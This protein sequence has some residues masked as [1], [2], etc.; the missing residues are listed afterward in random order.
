MATLQQC[1]TLKEV[2]AFFSHCDWK[3]GFL[4]KHFC[5]CTSPLMSFSEQSAHTHSLMGSRNFFL[6]L[7]FKKVCSSFSCFMFSP[8][9]F[10]RNSSAVSFLSPTYRV[11]TSTNVVQNTEGLGVIVMAYNGVHLINR[12][13]NVYGEEISLLYT[14][15]V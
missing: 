7:W 13:N 4:G 1:V 11:F 6:A 10:H 12:I 3:H 15:S 5:A 8:L 9:A 14:N 2:Q